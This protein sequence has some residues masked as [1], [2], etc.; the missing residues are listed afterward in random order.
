MCIGAETMTM[1]F[2]KKKEPF[3]YCWVYLQEIGDTAQIYLPDRRSG[4]VLSISIMVGGDL[5]FGAIPGA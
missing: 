5:N 3:I 4:Q 1:A 2:E